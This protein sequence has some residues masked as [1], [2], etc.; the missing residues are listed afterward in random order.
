MRL[1]NKGFGAVEGLIVIVIIAIIGVVGWR[2][3]DSSK[4]KKTTNQ[5]QVAETSN[6]TQTATAQSETKPTATPEAKKD[7]VYH[8]ELPVIVFATDTFTDKEKSDL[9]SKVIQPYIDF[10]DSDN[11][12]NY[13]IVSVE[14]DDLIRQ[15]MDDTYEYSIRVI[16]TTGYAGFLNTPKGQQIDWY[17]PDCM[18]KCQ[19]KDTFK[20][21]YPEL[22]KK[23]EAA[24]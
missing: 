11:T 18:D 15:G 2:V 6:K 17:Q 22:V 9:K 14:V 12:D 19:F 1:K 7:T 4:N 23:Y 8:P 3:Y 10:Y 16:S 24:N 13:A 5:T 20:S 21:K